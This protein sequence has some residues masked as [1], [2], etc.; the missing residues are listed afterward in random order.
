MATRDAKLIIRNNSVPNATFSGASLL[1]GEAIVNTADGIMMF[2]GVTQSTSEWT[3]AGTG[4]NAT[5]FEVGSNL[6]DLRLR[7]RITKYEDASGAGLVGKFLSGTTNG[8]VLADIADLDTVDTF[9]TGFTYTPST[10]LLTIKRNQGEPDLTAYID[11][12]S[13]LTINGTLS[14]TTLNS[15]DLVTSNL[16]ATTAN[17][18]NISGVNNLTATNITG[19]SI[20]GT[21]VYINGGIQTYSGLTNLSGFFL[22][23]TTNGFVLGATSAI[24]GVDTFVTGFTYNPAQNKIT[25]SQNVGQ[26]DKD[27]FIT[28]VSGLTISNLTPNRV[29]YTTTGGTLVT[30][31][32]IFDGTDMTLPTAGSLSVGTGGLVVGSGGGID[33][34]GTGDVVIHGSLT[35]FGASISAFTNDLYVEDPTITIN[36]NPTGSTNA[37]SLGSGIETQDGDGA[38]TDVTLK[39][40]ELFTAYPS[41]Y[42]ALTGAT[43][44]AFYTNLNDIVIRQSLD[45]S[46]PTAGQVGK[47]LLAEDDVLDGGSY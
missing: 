17:I 24:T 20:T 33:T 22:S 46:S 7:N 9:T 15:V 31:T 32:A 2:S 25:I 13:G 44:R 4:G 21:D 12:F 3:P 8:F 35:V 34:P 28:S 5:F 19:T 1:Q 16:T 14:A 38:N 27:I 11:S 41:E 10:N 42:T 26:A 45:T 6:Y 36:Y 30:G 40:E 39:I 37:T 23:G 18:T 43:N 29:V 47:R